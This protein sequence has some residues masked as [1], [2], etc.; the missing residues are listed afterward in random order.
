[1]VEAVNNKK[2]CYKCFL[3]SKPENQIR[4]LTGE[5]GT[6]SGLESQDQCQSVMK[7]GEKCLSWREVHGKK[8]QGRTRELLI[9]QFYCDAV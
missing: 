7:T 9:T 5:N 6:Y 2:L 1:M 8:E 3:L 4:S